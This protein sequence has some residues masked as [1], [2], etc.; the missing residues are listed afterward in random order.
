MLPILVMW[1]VSPILPSQ[2]LV[3]KKHMPKENT[4]STGTKEKL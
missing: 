3:V 4:E 2:A 1:L